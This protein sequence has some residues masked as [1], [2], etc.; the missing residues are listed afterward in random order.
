MSIDLTAAAAFMSTHA[1]LLDRRRFE[2]LAHPDDPD[3]ARLTLAALEAYRND[4]G[5]Y[6]YGLEPDL[7]SASSQL[8]GAGHAFETFAEAAPAVTTPRAIELCDWLTTISL[9]DGGVPFGLQV[10]DPAGCAPFWADAD[11]TVSSLQISAFVAL[12]A[13][14]LAKR[15]S[16]VAAH[17]WLERVTD[18]CFDAIRALDEE[19]FAL[20]LAFCIRL[21]DT[22]Y[23]SRPEAAELLDKLGRWVPA[24]GRIPVVGGAEGET[25]RALDLAPEPDKPARALVSKA[26]I[27]SELERVVAEQQDDGG[28]RVDFDNYSEAAVLE[29]R[30]FATVSAIRTLRLNGLT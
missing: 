17:P 29:W 22:V 13:H 24:D 21:L 2:L 16:A 30:G 7:R 5:G 3:L 10:D 1:R 4:D 28:W 9:P 15:D 25:L 12:N 11:P 20:I 26:V 18:Y 27:D 23:D 6:G 14:A 8:G 19:P